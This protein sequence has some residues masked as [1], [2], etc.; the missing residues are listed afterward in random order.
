MTEKE[1]WSIYCSENHINFDTSYEA[2]AF[3]GGGPIADELATLVLEG[4]K[5]ATASVLIA[6]ETEGD[7]VPQAGC[8]SVVLY[9]DGTAAG[10]IREKTELSQIDAW[11]AVFIALTYARD[12]AHA[13]AAD[14]QAIREA[15]EK[16]LEFV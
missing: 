3:C 16:F 4:T 2:W 7:P 6:Y 8:Y 1:M 5:T 13:T 11:T 12:T 10:V 15:V 9:D 14:A